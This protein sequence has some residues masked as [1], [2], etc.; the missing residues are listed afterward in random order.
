MPRVIIQN[1]QQSMV[2]VSVWNHFMICA[3]CKVTM[4]KQPF[5]GEDSSILISIQAYM[6][7]VSVTV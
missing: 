1:L 2:Q 7:R 5:D 3:L 4:L 6:S